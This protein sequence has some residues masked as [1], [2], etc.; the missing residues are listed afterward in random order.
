MIKKQ[1]SVI[2]GL[3]LISFMLTGC[4]PK[5]EHV[6]KPAASNYKDSHYNGYYNGGYYYR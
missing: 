3:L 2:L 5:N 6:G 4:I 1:I